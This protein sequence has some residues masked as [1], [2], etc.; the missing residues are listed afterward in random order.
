[1]VPPEI[2]RYTIDD[3]IALGETSS[4]KIRYEGNDCHRS[5]T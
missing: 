5:R 1:M 2:T 4:P 3:W